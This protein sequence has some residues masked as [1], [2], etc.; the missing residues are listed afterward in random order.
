MASVADMALSHPSLS[1]RSLISTRADVPDLMDFPPTTH[2]IFYKGHLLLVDW[3]QLTD[4][5]GED[6][7]TTAGTT[8][9]LVWEPNTDPDRHSSPLA[10]LPNTHSAPST[11]TLTSNT[12]IGPYAYMLNF[13]HCFYSVIHSFHESIPPTALFSQKRQCKFDVNFD[14]CKLF[15][16][17]MVYH[18]GVWL[19]NEFQS[20]SPSPCEA[21]TI[22][23]HF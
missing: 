5:Q 18:R 6:L 12:D 1:R 8:S 20:P 22:Q 17:L 3:H 2:G 10:I 21:N 13:L 7:F 9:C 11:H 15:L 14:T 4:P 23:K 19:M 16:W